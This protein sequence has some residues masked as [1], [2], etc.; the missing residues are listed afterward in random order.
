MAARLA[1]PEPMDALE[2]LERFIATPYVSKQH[3][4]VFL[5]AT[6]GPDDT[7]VKQL[8]RRLPIWAVF[9]PKVHEAWARGFLH[10]AT[11]AIATCRSLSC[12]K[13][14]WAKVFT[15]RQQ[16]L[17]QASWIRIRLLGVIPNPKVD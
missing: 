11:T 5:E 4:F 10:P 17:S 8:L 13:L 9:P 16:V 1:R 12:P 3:F 14:T 2:G 15:N 7:L 6:S